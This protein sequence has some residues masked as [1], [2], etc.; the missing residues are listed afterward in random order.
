MATADEIT[1]AYQSLFGRAPEAAGLDYWL[2]SGKSGADL[3]NALTGSA[4]G[5]DRSA[6]VNTSYNNLFGRDAETAGSNFWTSDDSWNK[7]ASGGL[8]NLMLQMGGGSRG[9]DEFSLIDNLK[10]SGGKGW[11][12]TFFDPSNSQAVWN[13]LL[14]DEGFNGKG[15]MPDLNALLKKLQQKQPTASAGGGGFPSGGYKDYQN[16][17]TEDVL[18]AAI[19]KLNES[20]DRQRNALGTQAFSAGAYGDARHGIESDRLTDSLLQAIGDLSATTNAQ[21]FESAMGWFNRDLD[22][23]ANIAYQ[24]ANLQNQWMGNQITGANTANNIGLNDYT[25]QTNWLSFLNNLDQYD[26]GWT[27]NDLN[28]NYQDYWAAQTWDQNQLTALLNVLNAI[29]GQSTTT[30]VNQQPDNSWASML[31][32]SL[33]SA[34]GGGTTK[35]GGYSTPSWIV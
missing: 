34:F 7:Y 21:G 3:T 27:Q 30:A 19:R 32:A 26:R 35:S 25:Q 20:G 16:P 18:N 31:G 13:S 17:F 8:D 5:S 11:A 15:A 1:Q 10:A 12:A 23:Q 4:Q 29:P 9:S 14:D 24:N 33:N 22:R 6:V 2:S 28:A